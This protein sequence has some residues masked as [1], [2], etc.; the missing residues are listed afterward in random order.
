M[1]K[2]FILFIF[3]FVILFCSQISLSQDSLRI[4]I[5]NGKIKYK[6]LS[7][8]PLSENRLK[9]SIKDFY[10]EEITGITKNDFSIFKKGKP[11]VILNVVPLSQSVNLKQ[12]VVLVL[13]NSASMA[14]FSKDLEAIID[15]LTINL[16]GNFYTSIVAFDE[17]LDNTSHKAHK[18]ISRLNFTKSLSELRDYCSFA[19]RTR[20]QRTYLNDAIM[21][22]IEAIRNDT[23]QHVENNFVVI[24]SDG[25]DIGSGFT[26][27]DIQNVD[28]SKIVFYSIDFM[29]SSRESRHK[30]IFLQKTAK[31]SGGEYFSP[32]DINALRTNFK[33]I[34]SGIRNMGY[35]IE[36]E[37]K[38]TK[39]SILFDLNTNE[40][41]QRPEPY[42]SFQGMLM[43]DM[44]MNESFPLLNYI[45]F[46]T[47]SANLP[48]RYKSF[49]R[50]KFYKIFFRKQN[51]R[52]CNSTLLSYFRYLRQKIK[53][54]PIFSNNNNRQH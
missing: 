30:N 52:R 24:L 37:Q 15:E 36:Y 44:K 50:F 13:D 34:S 41:A 10:G 12:R 47:N 31:E 17:S 20:S 19:L 39:P 11:T 53:G 48:S 5:K 3:F 14:P 16:S 22:A 18:Y 7:L 42:R 38:T 33:S 6:S 9:V 45:F 2:Q 8:Q 4:E 43:E 29:H 27:S 23:L 32:K 1:R 26:E 54:C 40:F 35:E 46:E 49:H 51:R 28:K 21:T 25:N